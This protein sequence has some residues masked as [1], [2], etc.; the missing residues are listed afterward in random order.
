MVHF[1]RSS[2]NNSVVDSTALEDDLSVGIDIAEFS[3]PLLSTP[4]EKRQELIDDFWAVQELRGEW[5]ETPG[6]RT[7]ETPD[8]FLGRRLREIGKKWNLGYV[9]D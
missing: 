3:K 2:D 5:F 8:E 7:E 9:T 1:L 4:E 6:L